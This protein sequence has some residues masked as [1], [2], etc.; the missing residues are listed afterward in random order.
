MNSSTVLH[1]CEKRQAG[2]ILEHDKQNTN[3]YHLCWLACTLRT[4][5]GGCGIRHFLHV[6]N[7]LQALLTSDLG[8]T[9]TRKGLFFGLTAF[10]VGFIQTVAKTN[11]LRTGI[12]FIS[13]PLYGL[14]ISKRI[15]VGIIEKDG[16]LRKKS[17][18]SDV[19]Q[20]GNDSHDTVKQNAANY[21]PNQDPFNLMEYLP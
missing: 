8:S 6:S 18:W 16:A 11:S 7:L 1:Y 14:L 12:I 19:G 9:F 4:S 20:H 13:S 2:E 10:R 17:K 21:E 5:S 15:L 3:E